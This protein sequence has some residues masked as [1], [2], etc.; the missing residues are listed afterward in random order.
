[1]SESHLPNNWSSIG[2]E[3]CL[4]AYPN[5]KK[6][7]QGWSPQCEKYPAESLDDWGVLKTSAIQDGYFLEEENKHLPKK[8][9]PKVQLEVEPGDILITCAGPRSRCG[10]T[11]LVRKVRPKLL[12][13]GKM[14]QL[15]VD[16]EIMER[17]LLELYLRESGTKKRIDEMKTGISDSGL[18]LTHS[19]F[20]TLEVPLPPLNEQERIVAKIE[21][22]FSEL[23]AG[24]A[25]LR[26]AK[27]QLGVYR[28]SLLKQAFEGKLTQT[29]RQEN[30]DQLESP[31]QLLARIQS[32][33]Q[34][35]Y[36][37]QLKE[38]EDQIEEWKVS[39]SKGKRPSM[40]RPPKTI[41]PLSSKELKD[42]PSL[43][44][45]WVFTRFGSLLL[46][47]RG[48]T[49]AVPK[50]EPTSIQ[51]L[52]SSS[53]RTA[54]IDYSDIRYL[55]EGQ[56]FS[57]ADKTEVNDLLFTRL[58]GTVEYVGN[59][60]VVRKE[61]NGT[62]IY[63]DRLYCAKLPNPSMASYVETAFREPKIRAFIEKRA[64]STAGHKRVSITDIEEVPIPLTSEAEQREIVSLLE[65]QFEVIEQ[66]E[67]EIDAALRRSEALRQS[68]LKKAFT[69]QLV[70]QDPTDEPA[71]QL[72]ARIQAQRERETPKKRAAKKAAPKTAKKR[73]KKPTN[74]TQSELPL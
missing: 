17:Q 46:S 12:I 2:I 45:R 3:D 34:S 66:N 53:V 35:R 23:E 68:I 71:S 57:D 41:D 1:M 13:S 72:L 11:C 19:R 39:G 70:P 51:I 44:S 67:R 38:W 24:E 56:K 49:T 8:L 42:L 14:Y 52:R 59:C 31:D 40:P 73:S 22:L 27:Q 30:P 74:P 43:P 60:A 32:E 21:E 6:I 16:S 29:W 64:K 65:A 47:I 20:S 9:E 26:Q 61:T 69:G 10:V 63:P 58:N 18:N 50:D 4:L 48:G 37:Q 62:L 55:V 25:S 5:G 15:R 28:Q 7:R 54:S 33:R 36:E